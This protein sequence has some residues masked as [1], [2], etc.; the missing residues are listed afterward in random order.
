MRGS[1]RDERVL[2]ADDKVL[3][4]PKPPAEAAPMCGYF[5]TRSIG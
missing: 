5:F 1:A 3:S 4:R 2:K